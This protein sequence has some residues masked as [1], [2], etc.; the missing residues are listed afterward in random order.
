MC[1][2]AKCRAWFGFRLRAN[3][4][5]FKFCYRRQAFWLLCRSIACSRLIFY[6][7]SFAVRS[8]S[9][10]CAGENS[11]SIY[12]LVLHFIFSFS[13]MNTRTMHC[14]GKWRMHQ[15]SLPDNKVGAEVIKC[16]WTIYV[17]LQN[18]FRQ[19]IFLAFEMGKFHFDS[20]GIKSANSKL[21]I[22]R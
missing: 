14:L 10:I 9:P 21:F 20:M 15:V 6:L 13:Q 2:K 22:E 1:Q 12:F 16:V 4:F 19:T 5:S 18:Y 17:A 3:I 7:F 8:S 11:F